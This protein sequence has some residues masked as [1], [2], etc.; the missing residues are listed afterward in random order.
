MRSTSSAPGTLT[1]V[2]IETRWYSSNGRLSSTTM[3]VPARDEPVELVGGDAR[4]GAGVLDEFAERLARHVDAG[5][6]LEPGRGPGGD[7]AVEDGEVGVAGAHEDI[8]ARVRPGRRRRRTARCASCARGT[9]RRESQL[10]P[11]QRHR[12]REQQMVLRED[13]LLAHIDQRELAPVGQHRLERAR[14]DLRRHRLQR[15]DVTSPA[16]A[17][18]GGSCPTPDRT[19]RAGCCRGW[20]RSRG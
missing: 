7:A 11:A 15:H 4:R 8:G 6:Q 1:A 18:S 2:G 20:C 13:Q 9:R 10:Q 5:K 16:A 19:A 12:A 17:S 3:S 14:V